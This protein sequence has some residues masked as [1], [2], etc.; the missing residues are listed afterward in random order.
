[1]TDLIP[2]RY[3]HLI[4][5]D[6][7]ATNGHVPDEEIVQFKSIEGPYYIFNRLASNRDFIRM[8]EGA[9]ELQWLEQLICKEVPI[10]NL[11]FYLTWKYPSPHLLSGLALKESGSLIVHEHTGMLSKA[12]H[13]INAPIINK[14]N[15]LS[16]LRKN[17]YRSSGYF[18]LPVFESSKPAYTIDEMGQ[19]IVEI[20]GRR[21]IAPLFE[22]SSR[23]EADS[24]YDFTNLN[25]SYEPFLKEE[26]KFY[27]KLSSFE[28][29]IKVYFRTDLTVLPADAPPKFGIACFE[30]LGIIKGEDLV[31]VYYNS[32][33]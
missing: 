32:V 17:I 29:D 8:F 2:G 10:E 5:S 20:N 4:V 18:Q 25:L 13:G 24:P 9:I 15:E 28:G 31:P 3:Y 1:M 19:N 6:K 12:W 26:K 33:F 22:I 7:N 21:K 11:P 14:L 23:H 30:T 27:D 16:P